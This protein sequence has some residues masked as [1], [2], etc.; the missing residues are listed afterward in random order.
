[1]D[2]LNIR[3]EKNKQKLI[4]EIKKQRIINDL[5][6]NELVESIIEK[7]GYLPYPIPNFPIYSELPINYKHSGYFAMLP[8]NLDLQ[9]H[10]NKFP[11]LNYKFVDDGYGHIVAVTTNGGKG[12]RFDIE[13]MIYVLGLLT[14][15]PAKH[16]DSIDE[17]G[18][19][20]INSTYI[21]NHFQDYL[22]YL[23]YLTSTG[24]VVCDEHYIVGKKSIGYKYATEY[25]NVPLVKYTY[26]FVRDGSINIEPIEEEVF[27]EDTKSLERNTLLN[28][29]Y[30]AYW[31]NQKMLTINEPKAD[32]YAYLLMCKKF[33]AGYDSWD[34]N[35][36]KWSKTRN[37]YCRKYPR[38]QYNA[39]L[40]NIIAITIYDYKAKIDTNVHR[41]HSV[42]TNMQKDYRNFLTY[43][44]QQLGAID[45]ANSQPYLM[46]LLFN[47][48]FWQLDSDVPL[49]I[50]MLPANIQAL[51]SS[52]HLTDIKNYTINN[53]GED[54]LSIY[55][56][57][58]SNGLVYEHIRD[59]ANERIGTN[60]E[61]DD[62]KVMM[63]IVF[64][65][66]NSFFNQQ[67]AKLKKLFAG[68]YPEIYGLIKLIKLYNHT[69]F[70]CLLQS[71]ES[72]V[73]LHRCCKRIW[74][75]HPNQV[76]VFTI[77][78]S[79]ATTIENKEYVEGV[80][81]EELTRAIGLPP[82]LKPELWREEELK[83]QDLLL[84]IQEGI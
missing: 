14:S 68:L 84:Q 4:E 61:R 13:R 30:L 54:E 18:Y 63:L 53:L 33:T 41:L 76:P 3:W 78:D 70:A 10:I 80:M 57:K 71:I 36:D 28:L 5:K 40:H 75:E 34:V 69:A 66:K 23:D 45:I 51:F 19:V 55:I 25:D 83:H 72:E 81:R 46:C 15:I 9:A 43:N 52:E 56:E 59:I 12:S 2:R 77:H 67:G 1:M 48:L 29:P 38:T 60:L 44:G 64:F 47:P 7:F 6:H 27:N 21:R 22:S 24:V 17:S 74:E 50:G 32:R 79:I 73:I 42:I 35:R 37:D 39:L 11:P 49:N 82:T 65:S 16:K 8:E 20:S 31:Y 26:S 58:A 62:A